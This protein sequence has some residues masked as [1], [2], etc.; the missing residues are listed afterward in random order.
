MPGVL[1][2]EKN[3]MNNDNGANDTNDNGDGHN[4]GQP[5]MER[6]ELLRLRCEV[7]QE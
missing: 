7:E 5:E 2:P 1:K 4:V 6:Q 3:R